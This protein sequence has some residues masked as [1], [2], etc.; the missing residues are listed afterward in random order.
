MDK[1]SFNNSIICMYV[2]YTL[3]L[4]IYATHVSDVVN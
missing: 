3:Y 1:S 2:G 4:L